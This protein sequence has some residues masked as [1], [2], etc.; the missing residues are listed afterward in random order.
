MRKFSDKI[1]QVAGS[2]KDLI[3]KIIRWRAM[4]LDRLLHV[5]YE[6][7]K[8]TSLSQLEAIFAD[9]NED[10]QKIQEQLK[11][12]SLAENISLSGIDSIEISD[13]ERAEIE[14]KKRLKQQR[15]M[16]AF[17]ERQKH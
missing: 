6:P 17:S 14:Y 4:Q 2:A 8:N 11:I 7:N 13:E 12:Q 10:P 9:V 16:Q 1:V 15:E 5:K 3:E